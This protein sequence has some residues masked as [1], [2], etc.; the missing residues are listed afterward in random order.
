M[1]R[2]CFLFR[3]IQPT[4]LDV[5]RPTVV[6]A[7]YLA[8]LHCVCVPNEGSHGGVRGEC[9]T[10]SDI[11]EAAAV[12]HGEHTR[13]FVASV[14]D[15]EQMGDPRKPTDLVELA[16]VDEPA[17]LKLVF[18]EDFFGLVPVDELEQIV[19]AEALE[20]SAREGVS[21]GPGKPSVFVSVGIAHHQT[22]PNRL[23]L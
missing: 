7:A 18:L 20:Q 3:R 22:E 8:I 19:R 5:D 17:H 1:R 21:R 4:V 16:V 2:G 14:F 12:F 6:R 23:V 9:G 13:L 11:E 15:H 10:V